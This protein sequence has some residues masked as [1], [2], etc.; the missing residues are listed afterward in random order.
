MKWAQH[1]LSHPSEQKFKAVLSSTGLYVQ[2]HTTCWVLIFAGEEPMCWP[3]ASCFL[4]SGSG[5]RR[6]EEG[7][8]WLLSLLP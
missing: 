3:P 6:T 4:V 8:A 7:G 2:P 1:T 5:G